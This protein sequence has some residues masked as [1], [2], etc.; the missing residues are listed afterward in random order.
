MS[1]NQ[2]QPK[3]ETVKAKP[4]FLTKPVLET[5]EEYYKF[6][7]YMQRPDFTYDQKKCTV[8]AEIFDILSQGQPT[9]FMDIKGIK[10]FCADTKKAAEELL[11]RKNA[12][13]VM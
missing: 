2:N 13:V 3:A 11:N 9:P 7:A 8:T 1:N 12:M 10:V 4:D 6:E 5:M